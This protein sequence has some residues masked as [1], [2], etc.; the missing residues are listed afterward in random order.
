MTADYLQGSFIPKD[1]LTLPYAWAS[2]HMNAQMELST[3][4]NPKLSNETARMSGQITYI[5][6]A[7]KDVPMQTWAN[8]CAASGMTVYGAVAVSWCKDA[9]I[10]QVWEGW[11]ASGFPLKPLPEFERPARFINAGLLPETNSL[12]AII[13][14]ADSKT[15]PICAMIAAMGGPL[16][17]DISEDM[18]RNAP[19]QVASFL[20][21]RM[22]QKSD[23]TEA[24][25]QLVETWSIT[26]A[27]TEYDIWGET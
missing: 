10:G 21:S 25:N 2:L 22:L 3:K 9:E 4:N 19:P 6:E 5:L 23:R 8:I 15:L 11:R 1:D 7:L 26:I 16:D 27:G 14:A 17:F 24:E 18:L 13:A 20:K 12:A